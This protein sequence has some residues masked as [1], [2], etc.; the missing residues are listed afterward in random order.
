MVIITL[1]ESGHPIF[2]ATSALDR[3]FLKSNKGGKSS[4]HFNSDL[5]N[6]ELL[7]RT[8][9]SVNQPSIYG[10]IAG[11]CGELAQ[12]ISDHAFSSPGK[13]AAHMNEQ[14]D[15]SLSPEVLSVMTEP[16]EIVVLAQGNLW[17]NHNVRFEHL[18]EEIKVFQTGEKAGFVKTTPHKS[19]FAV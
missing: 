13:P 1:K 9:N 7:L 6:A 5:S 14:L 2:R 16:L 3:G 18:P 15:C 8:T 11:W 12:Q 19:I 4:S 17:R 10:A